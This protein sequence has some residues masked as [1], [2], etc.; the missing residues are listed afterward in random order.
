MFLKLAASVSNLCWHD[1]G[2]D[3]GCTDGVALGVTVGTAD[4]VVL[5]LV[6]G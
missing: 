6:D 3:V 2:L 4:G 5:G 1:V